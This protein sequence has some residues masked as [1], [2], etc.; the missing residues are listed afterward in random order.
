MHLPDKKYRLPE[1]TSLWGFKRLLCKIRV[2]LQPLGE[3]FWLFVHRKYFNNSRLHYF[4]Q[5]GMG[6]LEYYKRGE[7]WFYSPPRCSKREIIGKGGTIVIEEHLVLQIILI[8]SGPPQSG[9]LP[10]GGTF[11]ETLCH[12][13]QVGEVLSHAGNQRLNHVFILQCTTLSLGLL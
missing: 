1:L 3:A 2:L 11:L 8:F 6:I 12:R 7:K 10:L 9:T 4:G 13:G 5:L